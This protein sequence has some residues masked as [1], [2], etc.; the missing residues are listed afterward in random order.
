MMMNILI[1]GGSG[2]IGTHVAQ[3]LKNDGHEVF[4]LTRNKHLQPHSYFH[5]I[6]WLQGNE[7]QL[8]NLPKMDI[9]INLAGDPLNKGRWTKKKKARILESRERTTKELIKLMKEMNLKPKLFLSASA[10]GIYEYSLTKEYTED[11]LDFGESFPAQVC[12]AWE[13][14]ANQASKELNI[15]TVIARFGIVLGK[16]S[17]AL[18]KMALPYH[19]FIGGKVAS[20]K[21]WVSWIHI[22]NVVGLIQH[23]IYEENIEGPVHFTAP[24]PVRMN[25]FGK[26]LGSVLHRPHWMPVPSFLLKIAFG[27]M[28]EMLINGQCVLPK[29]ALNYGYSFQYPTLRSALEDIYQKK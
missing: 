5:Y 8:Y 24:H 17:G 3:A 14:I 22:Q 28:S 6:T 25:E 21:Q 13:E 16:D 20:G 1:A 4:I 9:V 26:V 15:R 12:R 19:F 2:F 29:K 10:I 11:V 18:P 23:I 7:Y 27:E